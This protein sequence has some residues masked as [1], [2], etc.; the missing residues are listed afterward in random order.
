MLAGGCDDGFPPAPGT[1][2]AVAFREQSDSGDVCGWFA[3]KTTK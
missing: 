3:H 2:R 1:V